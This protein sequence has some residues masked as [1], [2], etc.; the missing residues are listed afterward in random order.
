[1]G[2]VPRMI[3]TLVPSSRMC[4]VVRLAMPAALCA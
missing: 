2:A 4:P 1:M 3:V